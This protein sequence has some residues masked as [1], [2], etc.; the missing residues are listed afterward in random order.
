[1]KQDADDADGD[2]NTTEKVPAFLDK[3]DAKKK[4]TSGKVPP[5]LQKYVKSKQDKSKKDLEEKKMT[6]AEKKEEEKLGKEMGKAKVKSKMQKQYGKEKGE[7]I[8]YKTKRKKAM[9]NA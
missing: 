8:Y 1:M 6:K 9:E 3:G 4:K 5:Q 2:G 7:E